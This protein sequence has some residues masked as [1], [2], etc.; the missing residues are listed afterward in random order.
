MIREYKDYLMDLIEAIDKIEQ[1]AE[2]P[3]Y[4]DFEKDEKTIFA[5]IRA[6]EVMGEAAKKIPAGVRNQYKQVPWKQMAGMRDKLIHEYFGVNIR[7]IWKTVKEDIPLV[8]PIIEQ[9][10]RDMQQNQGENK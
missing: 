6:L 5:V 4:E 3:A 7:V 10:V 9:M 2:A 1:F 8:K